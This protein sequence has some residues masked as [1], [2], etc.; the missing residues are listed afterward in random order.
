MRLSDAVCSIWSS[1]LRR[2]RARA[3]AMKNMVKLSVNLPE[4]SVEWLRAYAY[5]HDMTMTEAFRRAL[6]LQNL[7]HKELVK[8]NKVLLKRQDGSFHQL[9]RP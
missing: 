1:Y 5:V 6:G 8:G 2:E 3:R 7:I 4:E 9:I